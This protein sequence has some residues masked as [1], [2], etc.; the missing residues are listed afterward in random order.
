MGPPPTYTPRAAMH[1][2]H[3]DAKRR[4]A[5]GLDVCTSTGT[6]QSNH[7]PG[8]DSGLS[9]RNAEALIGVTELSQRSVM[10]D[11]TRAAPWA[12]HWVAER[13]ARR[14]LAPAQTVAA[15]AGER[16]GALVADRG[17][18][19]ARI[20]SRTAAQQLIARRVAGGPDLGSDFARTRTHQDQNHR[21]SKHGFDARSRRVGWQQ[22]RFAARVAQ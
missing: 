10:L 11:E 6:V 4:L 7:G 14:V 15:E 13:P 16:V 3:P 12:L 1:G 19:C 8:L 5:Q 21:G 17:R 9:L 2:T 18:P 22:P 20:A